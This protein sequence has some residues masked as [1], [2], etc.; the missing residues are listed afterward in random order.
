MSSLSVD[1]SSENKH[2][3]NYFGGWCEKGV[4]GVR[5]HPLAPDLVPPMNIIHFTSSSLLHPS[6]LE[7][8]HRHLKSVSSILQ[9]MATI[10]P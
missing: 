8:L 7:S 9:Q 3:V 10:T 6:R 2:S 5:V 4:V 1:A